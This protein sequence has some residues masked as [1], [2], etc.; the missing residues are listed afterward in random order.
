MVLSRTRKLSV[1]GDYR[2]TCCPFFQGMYRLSGVMVASVIG[3]WKFM[4]K[5][6]FLCQTSN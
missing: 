2:S 1:K 6:N 4:R 3:F 5:G